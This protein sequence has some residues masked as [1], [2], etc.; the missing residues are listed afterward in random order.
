MNLGKTFFASMFLIASFAVGGVK[1][2]YCS[3]LQD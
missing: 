2:R 3:A 1:R